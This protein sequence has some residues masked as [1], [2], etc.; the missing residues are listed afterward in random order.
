MSPPGLVGVPDSLC[1]FPTAS[2][3]LRCRPAAEDQERPMALPLSRRAFLAAGLAAAAPAAR[4]EPLP[5][6]TDVHHQLLELATEHEKKRRERF[7]AVKSDA[8]L[9]AL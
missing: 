9:E 1:R 6:T 3:I 7:A 8:D 2:V 4:G 5:K